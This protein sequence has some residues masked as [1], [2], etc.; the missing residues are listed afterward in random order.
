MQSWRICHRIWRS[1][2][3]FL[4]SAKQSSLL[5]PTHWFLPSHQRWIL[6]SLH[7]M[8][9][10]YTACLFAN[11]VWTFPDSIILFAVALW[12][13][14]LARI[15]NNIIFHSI[16]CISF[17][18]RYVLLVRDQEIL[19]TGW[20]TNSYYVDDGGRYESLYSC[21]QTWIKN[22]TY[23]GYNWATYDVDNKETTVVSSTFGQSGEGFCKISKDLDFDWFDSRM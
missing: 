4:V 23:D 16:T 10:Q 17:I 22:S 5:C 14:R 19:Y 11:I 2:A 20:E 7:T 21:G 1:S 12:P 6:L 18:W 8:P 3:C 13:F 15:I 9:I